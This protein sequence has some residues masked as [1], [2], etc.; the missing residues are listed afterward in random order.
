MAKLS[1]G[2]NFDISDGIEIAKTS[3]RS[4]SAKQTLTKLIAWR[5]H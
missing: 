2:L 1:G 5:N 4:G 3:I